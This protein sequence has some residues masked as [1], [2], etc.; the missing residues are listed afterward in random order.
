MAVL[1]R[2]VDVGGEVVTALRDAQESGSEP[3][4]RNSG[5]G[6]GGQNCDLVVSHSAEPGC[7]T[8]GCSLPCA[9]L[10]AT[11]ESTARERP[12][13]ARSASLWFSHTALLR[14]IEVALGGALLLAGS[15]SSRNGAILFGAA[16][17]MAGFVGA[18]QTE[19]LSKS[20]ALESSMAWFGCAIGALVVVAALLAPRTITRSS[21]VRT[22]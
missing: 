1:D 12:E 13:Q 5:S 11:M 7:L 10:P 9:R 17:A 18:V 21:N 8:G 20:L 19:F 6:F 15:I 16:A 2:P 22:A 14:V 3:H 4:A